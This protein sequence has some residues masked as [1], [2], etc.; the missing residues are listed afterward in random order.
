ME[1]IKLLFVEDDPSFSFIIKGSLELT[2][3]YEVCLASNGKEGLKAYDSFVPDIIASDIEMPI[4]DGLQMVQLIRQKNGNI[5]IVFATGRTSA[6]DVVEGYRLN[7]DNF[8]K[9]PF[10]P[11]ELDAHIQAILKRI[12]ERIIIANNSK[13]VFLGEYTFN[14]A[15]HILQWHNEKQKMTPREADILWLLYENKNQ[16]VKRSFLLEKLWG[17]S[18]FFTSRSLDVFTT[19][20]RKYLSFDP[21]I[22]IETIHRE[23]LKLIFP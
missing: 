11:E 21:N 3:M 19:S 20:L 15:T 14:M 9:K 22:Q 1:K 16:V 10:I 4:M 23:G 18:D 13:E 6:Q 8:I 5:P 7:V 2:G 12:K 17:I